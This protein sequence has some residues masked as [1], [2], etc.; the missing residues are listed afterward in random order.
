MSLWL[1]GGS[2]P[3]KYSTPSMI[4]QIWMEL[5]VRKQ[6][7]GSNKVKCTPNW[8]CHARGAAGGRTQWSDLTPDNGFTTKITKH[9]WNT[10]SLWSS[11]D[12]Q[13]YK[14]TL[15]L[16]TINVLQMRFR[17]SNSG[18]GLFSDIHNYHQKQY[19]PSFPHLEFCCQLENGQI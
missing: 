10:G 13:A 19:T 4:W 2:R 17:C 14:D 1:T 16:C 6:L 8:I 12:P 11:K 9:L 5:W 7:E 3:C 18:S 15:V